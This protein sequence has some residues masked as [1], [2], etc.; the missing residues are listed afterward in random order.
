[1]AKNI[2]SNKIIYQSY[3]E[4]DDKVIL[5]KQDSYRDSYPMSLKNYIDF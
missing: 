4:K 3:D 2:I 1:M 5:F